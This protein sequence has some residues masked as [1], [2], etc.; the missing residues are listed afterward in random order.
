MTHTNDNYFSLPTKRNQTDYEKISSS[1]GFPHLSQYLLERR[2]CSLKDLINALT[3]KVGGNHDDASM[4]VDYDEEDILYHLFNE[5]NVKQN[6][7]FI[8][9]DIKRN[10]FIMYEQ[11]S[12][13]AVILASIDEETHQIKYCAIN[14]YLNIQHPLLLSSTATTTF[15]TNDDNNSSTIKNPVKLL[16]KGKEKEKIASSL[17][18]H[19]RDN[20]SHPFVDKNNNQKRGKCIRT[21]S[22][23]APPFTEEKR[24]ITNRVYD[25]LSSSSLQKCNEIHINESDLYNFASPSYL[26]VSLSDSLTGLYFS[27]YDNGL[28][29]TRI[30]QSDCERLFGSL[31]CETKGKEHI[32][33]PHVNPTG[34]FSNHFHSLCR[35]RIGYVEYISNVLGWNPNKMKVSLYLHEY[36]INE[37]RGTNSCWSHRK[38]K[39]ED[40][41]GKSKSST[42]TPK[43][44]KFHSREPTY[45]KTLKSWTL[46]YKGRAKY[47]SK[48]NFQ[49]VWDDPQKKS[50][51]RNDEENIVLSFGKLNEIDTLY[52]IDF[53]SPFTPYSA[54]FVCLTTFSYKLC[55]S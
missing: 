31:D 18:R 39:K 37:G 13:R 26:G 2:Y 21:C 36:L 11:Q 28:P 29:N 47:P 48:R 19:R 10:F 32:K 8:L 27:L 15:T 52:S 50:S 20:V 30:Q 24:M 3:I 38:E 34:L 5:E 33:F 7:T 40:K 49:L 42:L 43:E 22:G 6:N 35:S 4:K 12:M 1:F 25:D 23:D 44:I 53:S 45:S 9:D 54:L 46:N 14:E 51:N 16:E 17:D 41:E 55:C